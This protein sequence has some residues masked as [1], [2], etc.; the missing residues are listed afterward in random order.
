MPPAPVRSNLVQQHRELRE[1]S[2]L[3]PVL[4]PEL[5]RHPR[6]PFVVC[7]LQQ[8]HDTHLAKGLQGLPQGVLG[9]GLFVVQVPQVNEGLRKGLE[10]S[11][12]VCLV[13][14]RRAMQEGKAQTCQDKPVRLDDRPDQQTQEGEVL[15]P[16]GILPFSPRLRHA[17]QA[18]GRGILAVHLDHAVRGH[19]VEGHLEVA[20]QG[21]VDQL[22]TPLLVQ[23]WNGFMASSLRRRWRSK[24]LLAFGPR[25]ARRAGKDKL[26]LEQLA[27][28]A[29]V[30]HHAVALHRRF[31]GP[32]LGEAV[33]HDGDD[34]LVDEDV[35]AHI[36]VVRQLEVLP[37][38]DDVDG[39]QQPSDDCDHRAEDGECRIHRFANELAR[40]V[41]KTRNVS[42][43]LQHLLSEPSHPSDQ[44]G[45][46]D[47]AAH[48][49]EKGCADQCRGCDARD[50]VDL[51]Q[52]MVRQRLLEHREVRGR[53]ARVERGPGAASALQGYLPLDVS[54]G[55]EAGAGADVD[56]SISPAACDEEMLR[57]TDDITEAFCALLGP[58]K[59][60]DVGSGL[61]NLVVVDGDWHDIGIVDGAR[62]DRLKQHA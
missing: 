2:S 61:H 49:A 21:C 54:S 62:K 46:P 59:L 50:A 30:L 22:G 56:V 47:A 55:A 52:D 34:G 14:D 40:E 16:Q 45:A 58:E 15:I 13:H 4:L 5:K 38:R 20:H 32:S 44:I 33:E 23:R 17:L 48:R 6:H 24:E 41:E 39:L 12:H 26:V 36:P 60:S 19:P 9:G 27:Q 42:T 18:D 7:N 37:G 51:V 53:G 31:V 11:E 57:L 3:S 25:L 1:A 10:A 35:H 29:D 8:A 28:E 43:C